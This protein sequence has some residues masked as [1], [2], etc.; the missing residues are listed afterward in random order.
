[1]MLENCAKLLQLR[2]CESFL[3]DLFE[4]P[5]G[6]W[7]NVA[8][9]LGRLNL[10]IGSVEDST[11]V[12]HLDNPTGDA[13]VAFVLFYDANSGESITAEYNRSRLI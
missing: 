3:L 7:G 6:M 5:K 9:I 1:M 12:A 4:M 11:F 13:N 8:E 2:H 10:D